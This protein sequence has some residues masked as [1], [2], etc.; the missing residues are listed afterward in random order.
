VTGGAGD[1]STNVFVLGQR[2]DFVTFDAADYPQTRGAR[3][4]GHKL[5]TLQ[6]VANSRATPELFGIGYYEMVA[7]QITTELQSLRYRLEPG[8]SVKLISKGISFGVLS[9]NPDGTWDTTA[10]QGLPQPSVMSEG[11]SYAPSLAILPFHQNGQ[12]VSLRVFTVDAFNQHHGMQA[13]E[14]FGID[15]DPDGDGIKNELTRADITA[16]TIFQATLPVPTQQLPH[17]ARLKEAVRKGEGLF[18]QIGAHLAT[19]PRCRSMA[20]DGYSL[21][22]MP[23]IQWAILRLARLRSWRWT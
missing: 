20:A 17:D 1:L 7:R 4:E 18:K 11:A 6:S 15:T 19:F 16:I 9:R 10:V 2:F 5:V 22:Q 14:R 23:T 21:S 3:D 12:T 13:T 8:K